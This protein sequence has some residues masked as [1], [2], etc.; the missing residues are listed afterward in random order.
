MAT[1][2]TKPTDAVNLL[3]DLIRFPSLTGEEAEIADFVEAQARRAGV[4]VLRHEDNVAFGVGDGDDTLVLNSHL[5]VVPPADGHPYAPFE[6]VTTDGVLYGRGSVD[7]KA[8]GAAMTT[9]LLSLADEGWRPPNGQVLVG[10]TTHEE[11]GGRKNGL[12]DLRPHLPSLSAAVVGEPTQLRPCIA[13]K[14]LLILKLHAQGQAAH[15]GRAHL[16]ENAIPAAIT[17]IQQ[18]EGLSLN[19]KDPHLGA[20]TVTVTTID[21]GDAHNVVPEHCVCTVDCRTTPAYTHAEIV[22]AVR[23]AV[24]AEVEVYSD[25]LVPCATPMDARIVRAG[26]SARPDAEPFGSPTSSDWVFLHDVPTVKM[27]P[28]LSDR[29]HTAEERID[30]SEVREAV[31]VYQALIQSYFSPG[32]DGS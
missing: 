32:R 30:V 9:A 18:L 4:D 16:G 10:L 24:D 17:A 2:L 15:A 13:Q 7:A 19:R 3:K 8:S 11:S 25:R 22:E 14:G 29:S 27:G 6:P 28:G 20:P 12:R 1:R 23:E 21:G 5:D 31:D 26:Q